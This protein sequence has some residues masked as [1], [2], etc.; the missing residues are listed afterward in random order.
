MPVA[1]EGRLSDNFVA[2]KIADLPLPQRDIFL[3][4]KLSAGATAIAGSASST[5]LSNSPVVTVNGNRYRGNNYVLDGAVNVNPNNTGRP[6]IVPTLESV[7]EAQV[8]TGNFSSEFGRGNGAVINLRTKSGTNEIHG[9]LWEYHR[10]TRLNARNF[11]AVTRPPVVFNQFG[12][13]VGGPVIKNKTFFFGS[14]EGTR[15][16]LGQALTFQVET[17]EFRDYVQRTTPDSVAAQ[18]LRRYP[19][20]TPQASSGPSK[21]VG[22]INLTTPEGSLPAI[23][24]A[25]VTL[26]NYSYS[27][28]Y[29]GRLDHSFNEGLD[30][31]SARW[32]SENQG[33]IGKA[34]S[35][36]ATL[37]KAVRGSFGPFSGKF[38]NLNL[39]HMHVFKR[40]VNDARF[41][42]QYLY[43]TRGSKDAITP[44]ITITGITAPFGDVFYNP[45]RFRT[46]EVRDT[47]TL[48]RGRHSLRI[49]FE[50]RRIFK[51]IQLGPATSGTY[52]F[53]I[54]CRLRRRSSVPADPHRQSDH[55]RAHRLSTLLS[56]KRRRPIPSG[57]LESKLEIEYQSGREVRLLW[58]GH[59]TGRL[60]FLVGLG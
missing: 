18:L 19:A 51:G 26:R 43:A 49:G 29:L 17:P 60:D 6:A 35:A 31:I 39:G 15:S 7:E 21:Y 3:L 23:G 58:S 54:A 45:S 32:I 9:R 30:K 4:P 56:S 52:A 55:R 44:D 57:R 5:K 53:R 8:E 38:A 48:D 33:D 34:S 42:F 46:Y 13:S 22:Q 37:G 50:Y 11:F 47:L 16:V 2:S 24:R 41:S 25:A 10:N 1:R 28:Q 14:Y 40:A 36:P 12:A 27:D 20:P 59:R